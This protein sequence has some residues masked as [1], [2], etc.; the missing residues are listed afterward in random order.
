[1]ISNIPQMYLLLIQ[2]K[3]FYNH[4]FNGIFCQPILCWSAPLKLGILSSSFIT[5]C[6]TSWASLISVFFFYSPL[7]LRWIF[8]LV[9]ELDPS[10]SILTLWITS[11]SFAS[12]LMISSTSNAFSALSPVALS[13]AHRSTIPSQLGMTLN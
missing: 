9:A 11:S 13:F 10:K 5:L 6:I 3:S 7:L 8:C 2:W 4:K 1:M 12:L